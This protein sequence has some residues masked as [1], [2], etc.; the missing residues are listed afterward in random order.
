MFLVTLRSGNFIPL[1]CRFEVSHSFESERPAAHSERKSDRV[2][3][4]GLRHHDVRPLVFELRHRLQLLLGS[5]QNSMVGIPTA[6]SAR[7]SVDWA[8]G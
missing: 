8:V 3:L 2:L 7:R 4:S 5:V 6:I 1:R